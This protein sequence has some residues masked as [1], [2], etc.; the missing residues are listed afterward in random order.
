MGL[1][2]RSLFPKTTGSEYENTEYLDLLKAHRKNF[3]LFSG[4]S[5]PDQNGKEPHDTELTWLTAARNPGLAGFKNTISVDQ[6]AARFLGNTTRFPSILLSSNSPESQSYTENGVMLPGLHRPSIVFARLFLED[7]PRGLKRQ[8][9]R[10]ADG[11]SILDSVAE[12]TKSLKRKASIKDR[13][14]LDE[15]LAAIRAA[16]TE[17]A[18]AEGKPPELPGQEAQSLARRS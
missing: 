8:R 9:Q 1:Y 12:Q 11:R 17:S 15:Y 4:L 16:E 6:Q 13:R 7:S 10:L 2:P 3:T 18:E 14:Q 5:H